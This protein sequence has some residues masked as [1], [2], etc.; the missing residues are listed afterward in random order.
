MF[1]LACCCL[2]IRQMSFIIICAAAAVKLSPTFYLLIY[3]LMTLFLY[4][5]PAAVYPSKAKVHH[6]LI[7]LFVFIQPARVFRPLL[8]LCRPFFYIEMSGFEPRASI[9]Y[10]RAI[11]LA[12]VTP[13]LSTHLKLNV[14][15]FPGPQPELNT[16]L[17]P[18]VCLQ[19]ST[20]HL[21]TLQVVFLFH[22]SRFLKPIFADFCIH[23][24]NEFRRSQE[25][26][27]FCALC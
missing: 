10:K 19:P 20:G 24:N 6:E 15:P 9:A 3:V 5:T 22:F 8:C 13:N 12:T 27:H 7:K 4:I 17:N 1:C 2:Y 23:S 18:P 25:G 21:R 26:D 16:L 11:K 14:R